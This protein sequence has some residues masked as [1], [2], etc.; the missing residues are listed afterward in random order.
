L[1]KEGMIATVTFTGREIEA[2][3]VHKDSVVRST[4]GT[5]INV[6]QPSPENPKTGSTFQMRVKTGIGK[7]EWMQVTP[8]PANPGEP[9]KLAP[10]MQIVTDGA[11]RLMPVHSNVLVV[12]PTIQK[13]AK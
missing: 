6:F 1:L 5:S 12:E 10:D 11:E 7:G 3:L 2:F 9:Q 13:K 8:D 4:N